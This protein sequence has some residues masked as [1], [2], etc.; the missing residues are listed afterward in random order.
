M[1]ALRE[2]RLHA[3]HWLYAQVAR[4]LG[5]ALRLERIGWLRFVP[6]I[7]RRGR[8]FVPGRWSDTSNWPTPPALRTVAGIERDP[9][10]E[11]Q[12]LTAA[13]PRDFT[14]FHADASNYG[15][16]HGWGFV[17]PTG[18]RLARALRRM[19]AIRERVP[20]PPAVVD[21]P[22]AL[23]ERIREAAH[24]AGLSKVGFA[25]FDPKYSFVEHRADHGDPTVIVCL[26]EQDYEATQRAPSVRAERGAFRAYGDLITGMTALAEAIQAMGFSARPQSIGAEMLAIPYG[27]EAG[28]GQL[29]LNGQL[30]TP[31]AGSRA[32]LGLITSNVPV[33]YGRPVDY[34]IHAIC[35]MCQACVRRCPVGAIPSRRRPHH[36]VTKAKIKT[37]RCFPVVSSAH[38]CAICIKV[39]PIQKYGLGAVTDHYERTG[40]VLGRDTD[41]LEAFH[42]PL[43][44]LT[45]KAGSKPRVTKKLL[46][47]PGFEFDPKRDA[48]P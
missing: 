15:L 38:G 47:P 25:R 17:L 33:V 19:R 36:G 4:V 10:V 13:P 35:D 22:E 41:A 12:A 23:T 46:H 16:G 26:L 34:G 28:L 24:R 1:R 3:G 44:G 21:S 29:G 48:A 20:P 8:R 11:E 9:V 43:D 14:I 42:W 30:L 5:P 32:R 6:S 2:A 18:G 31:E 40:G 7:P 27:V 39:C 45:Y 37:E